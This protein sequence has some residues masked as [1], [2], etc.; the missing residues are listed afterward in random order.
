MQNYSGILF[1]IN[2]HHSK[3]QKYIEWLQM[4]PPWPHFPMFS[5]LSSR[6]NTR[7]KT[8]VVAHE[9][10]C[11]VLGGKNVNCSNILEKLESLKKPG[12]KKSEYLSLRKPFEIRIHESL[13]LRYQL[14]QVPIVSAFSLSSKQSLRALNEN[15]NAVVWFRTIQKI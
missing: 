8:A 10:K 15:T 1:E 6:I 2:Y 12:K 7:F 13:Y 14:N 11:L 5:T 4:Q 3:N 9:A